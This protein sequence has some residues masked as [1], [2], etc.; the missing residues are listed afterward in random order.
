MRLARLLLSLG[1]LA[2]LAAGC[3]SPGRSGAEDSSDQVQV[4]ASISVIGDLTEEV[5]GDRAEV[6]TIVPAGAD[7]HTFQPSP[8]DAQ[9]ISGSEV[10]FQNGL[11]LEDWMGDLVDSAG[12]E[13]VR[14]VELAEGLETPEED[15]RHGRGI[16]AR[17]RRTRGP[18][19]ATK[20]RYTAQGN[21]PTS[22]L[23]ATR[24][25]G[26]TYKTPSV[27]SR[28]SRMLWWR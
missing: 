1:L 10:V 3:G 23:R 25:C 18:K 11:G 19:K 21:T 16:G 20:G 26:S 7:V 22:T 13:D 12:G 15:D 14:V 9:K 2:A 27:T 28:R 5:A 6:F 4:A 17:E 8:S 24:T